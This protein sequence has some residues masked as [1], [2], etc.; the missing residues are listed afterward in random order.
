MENIE[1][2]EKYALRELDD[3]EEFTHDGY[4]KGGVIHVPT[5]HIHLVYPFIVSTSIST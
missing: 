2:E 4:G 1:L 3:I 5:Q